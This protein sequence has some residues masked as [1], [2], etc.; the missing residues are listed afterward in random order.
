MNGTGSSGAAARTADW[1]IVS[2]DDRS[3][4]VVH[5]PHSAVTIPTAVREHLL[6]SEDELDNELQRMTDWGTAQL[7]AE[8]SSRA[9]VRP[10]QFVNQLSRMVVDPE[11]FPDE[12]EEMRSVGMGAVYTRTSLGD[13]LRKDWAQH[14]AELLA[15]YFHPYAAAFA[16]LVDDRLASTGRATIIDV[17]SFPADALPYE[18][19]ANDRRPEVCLGV[20]DQHTPSWLVTAAEQAF[21]GMDVAVNEPFRGTYVPLRHYGEDL[22]VSSIMIELR[23][24]L[25]PESP[26]AVAALAWLISG[27]L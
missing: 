16:D 7:A 14:E 23:R 27:I 6:L 9:D 11:R 18:L 3:P 22:R 19:H 4:V 12:R 15:R 13:P 10:W 5:V 25:P 21:D 20:D 24:D 1:Q 17:H 2:G 26:G 8:S